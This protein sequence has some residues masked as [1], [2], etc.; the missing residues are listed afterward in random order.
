MVPLEIALSTSGR[1]AA[2]YGRARALCSNAG[3][4]S[5]A[6]N[7]KKK[8]VGHGRMWPPL[9]RFGCC[10]LNLAAPSADQLGR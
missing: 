4:S 10:R 9:A 7:Q 1:G 5:C 6:L 8:V 3:K 2:I